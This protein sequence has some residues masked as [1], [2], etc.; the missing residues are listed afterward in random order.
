M[1]TCMCFLAPC[2]CP[3][4]ATAAQEPACSALTGV[5]GLTMRAS[6]GRAPPP[7]AARGPVRS[8]ATAR[9]PAQE[10][11]NKC[12]DIACGGTDAAIPEGAAVTAQVSWTRPGAGPDGS[13]PGQCPCCHRVGV[14]AAAPVGCRVVRAGPAGTPCELAG[15]PNSRSAAAGPCACR[16]LPR[17]ALTCSHG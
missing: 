17:E 14:I 3:A 15:S 7:P 9:A 12:D 2:A 8:L 11:M 4:H 16:E 10:Y 6:C 1:S 5:G 13:G